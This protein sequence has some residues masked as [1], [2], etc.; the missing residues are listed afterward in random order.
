MR[1][2]VADEGEERGVEHRHSIA[3]SPGLQYEARAAIVGRLQQDLV[4]G[5]HHRRSRL[6][7]ISRRTSRTGNHSASR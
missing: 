2:H 4:A 3:R 5:Q 1:R 6:W 7:R